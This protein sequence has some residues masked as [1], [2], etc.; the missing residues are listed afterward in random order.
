MA[1][2]IRR[3]L[4][5]IVCGCIYNKDTRKRVRVVLNSSMLSNLRFIRRNTGLRLQKIKTFI[6]YQARSLLISVN[7][8]YIF[9]FPLRR[10]DTDA[11]TQREVRIVSALSPLSPIY[12][13]PVDVFR[14]RGQLVRRYEYIRGTMWRQLP[15]DIALANVDK[16]APQIANFIYTIGKSDPEQIRDLKPDPDMSPRYMYGWS[17]C[18]ICDNFVI[19]TKTMKI[20]AFIDWEDSAFADFSVMMFNDRRSPNRELMD[21]VKRE[22]D[23]LY[24]RENPQH[25]GE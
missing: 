6:G 8:K 2:A 5:N 1:G 11:L 21:A 13:P 7:D 9:K 14:H 15:R 10:S 4:T 20:I 23:K 22:Y 12:V 19:D 17:Q 16:L 24:Y 18:D 25:Q 3:F